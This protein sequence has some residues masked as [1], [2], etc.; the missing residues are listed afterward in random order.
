VH[1]LQLSEFRHDLH[2]DF[3]LQAADTPAQGKTHAQTQISA[4]R[5]EFLSLCVRGQAKGKRATDWAAPP[6]PTPH[7]AQ[8]T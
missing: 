5:K 6:S 3:S 1:Q 2:E 8:R 7:T 4:A